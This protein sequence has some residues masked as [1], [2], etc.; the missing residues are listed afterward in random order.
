MTTKS[1]FKAVKEICLIFKISSGDV[2]S[3]ECGIQHSRKQKCTAHQQGTTRNNNVI[4]PNVDA[5][6]H[7][8]KST[9]LFGKICVYVSNLMEES[10]SI[11]GYGAKVL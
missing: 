10:S 11:M 5:P 6:G 3:K 1:T 2:C 4:I 9:K 8:R 7:K